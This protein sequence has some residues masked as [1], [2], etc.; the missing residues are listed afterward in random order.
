MAGSGIRSQFEEKFKA[1]IWDIEDKVHLSPRDDFQL[2]SA[3]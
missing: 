2:L 1:L 3:S